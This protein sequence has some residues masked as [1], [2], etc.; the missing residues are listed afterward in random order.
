MPTRFEMCLAASRVLCCDRVS[1]SVAS[2][3]ELEMTV[4]AEGLPVRCRETRQA[5]AAL[6][7]GCCDLRLGRLPVCAVGVFGDDGAAAS[8]GGDGDCLDVAR[9]SGCVVQLVEGGLEGVE[10][11][12][13]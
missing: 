13:E 7:T 10:G 1:L 9:F 11:A 6:D 3:R 2:V 4:E 5:P 8:S 12:T